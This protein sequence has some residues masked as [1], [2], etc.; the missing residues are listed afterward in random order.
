ME[1][2][3]NIPQFK[4]S[5]TVKVPAKDRVKIVSS[6]E[7]FKI[8][9]AQ[10][11][12]SIFFQESFYLMLLNRDNKVIGVTKLSS[13][14]T[15]MAVVDIKYIMSAAFLANASGVI[16]CHNHPSDNLVP[17]NNDAEMTKRVKEA[18][19]FLDIQIMDHLILGTGDEYYSFADQGAL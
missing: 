11:D 2:A 1:Q 18:L 5:W 8:F 12:D 7:A 10:Y 3:T 13:G 17:S 19:R 16:L 9:K 4:L 6:Y 14:G 15:A